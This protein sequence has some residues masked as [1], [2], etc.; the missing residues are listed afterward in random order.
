M[1]LNQRPT[2]CILFVRVSCRVEPGRDAAGARILQNTRSARLEEYHLTQG[3]IT[4]RRIAC[5]MGQR[6]LC[7]GLFPAQPR[8]SQWATYRGHRTDRNKLTRVLTS[9]QA[10]YSA[11][12]S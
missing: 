7:A 3:S 6:G 10:E 12:K 1:T 4:R 5:Y 9:T 2:C 8:L 11:T